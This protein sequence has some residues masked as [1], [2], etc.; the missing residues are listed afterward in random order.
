MESHGWASFQDDTGLTGS[1][2]L[3]SET[4]DVM[5]RSFDL[6]GPSGD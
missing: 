4:L 1:E 5:V 3:I 2:V 6:A